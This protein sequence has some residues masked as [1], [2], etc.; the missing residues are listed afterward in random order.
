MNMRKRRYKHYWL[1]VLRVKPPV[2][3]RVTIVQYGLG[4]DSF[5]EKVLAEIE[6]NK[7]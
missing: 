3:A 5:A 6:F 2:P 7:R 1:P 4:V